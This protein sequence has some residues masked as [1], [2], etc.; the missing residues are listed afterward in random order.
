MKALKLAIRQLWEKVDRR[1]KKDHVRALEI[2]LGVLEHE[3]AELRKE[4]A[5]AKH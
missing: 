4:V 3:V 2:R 1:A 5:N